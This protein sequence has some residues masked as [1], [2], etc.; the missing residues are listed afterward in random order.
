VQE[1]LR[2]LARAA[3]QMS[4]VDL[5]YPQGKHEIRPPPPAADLERLRRT[6]GGRVAQLVELYSRCDGADLPDVQNG[7]FLH[8]LKTVLAAKDN[9]EPTSVSGPHGGEVIVVG[10]DGGG[11]RFAVRTSDP[12]G[13]VL[14][15][16]SEGGVYD[17]VFNG[18]MAKVVAVAPDLAGFIRRLTDDV[19]AFVAGDQDWSYLA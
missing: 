2:E 19:R 6:A 14:H 5:G 10:S 12:I 1:E 13:E 17:G 3:A 8:S 15:L 16:D 7:Y 18:T 11:G 9:G 4:E